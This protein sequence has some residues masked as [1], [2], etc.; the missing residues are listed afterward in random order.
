MTNDN[1]YLVLLIAD[2]YGTMHLLQ[3][4]FVRANFRLLPATTFEEAV[5]EMQVEMPDIVVCDTNVK[6]VNRDKLQQHMPDNLDLQALPFIYL[7]CSTSSQELSWNVDLD[8]YMSKP[9]DSIALA[10]FAHWLLAHLQYMPQVA[11]AEGQSGVVVNRKAL[12]KEVGR[13]LERIE[14]YGNNMSICILDVVDKDNP[15]ALT[16]RVISSQILDKADEVLS[17]MIRTTDFLT[18]IS[19]GRFLWAMPVTDAQGAQSALAQLT[20]NFAKTSVADM[21]VSWTIHAGLATAP[22]DGLDYDALVESAETNLTELP[23]P[24]S[25]KILRPVL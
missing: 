8:Q 23:I 3:Q 10:S 21:R 4:T 16:R 5:S 18:R 11:Q 17:G 2:D 15:T 20:A 1:R 25:G 14:R 19:R 9:F 12:R 22:D 13:E 6:D 7:Y 24:H